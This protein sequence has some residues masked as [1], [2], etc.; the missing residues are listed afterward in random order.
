M[1]DAVYARLKAMAA[2]QLRVR[3]RG[4]LDTTVL[5]HELYLRIGKHDQLHFD[6]PAQFFAYA[7]QAMR[8]LLADHARD[9]LRQRA[10]G[11]W[12]AITL[13]GSD[14]GLALEDAQGAL[15]LDSALHQLEAIDARA[16]RVVELRYFA[17]LPLEQVAEQLGV[18]RRT[19]DRDWAFARA[20]LHDQLA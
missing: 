15:A 4:T 19:V 7:A 16:A 6:D 10:G 1:F 11:G 14:S 9:H 5:V 3:D 18:T 13:S 12:V 8:H 2:R 20:F 17:G